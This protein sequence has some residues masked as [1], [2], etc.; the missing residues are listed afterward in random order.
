MLYQMLMGSS[1]SIQYLVVIT[2]LSAYSVIYPLPMCQSVCVC[3]SAEV[4]L[5][6]ELLKHVINMSHGE[7]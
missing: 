4:E 2:F 7:C 1:H 5:F 3:V 6:K